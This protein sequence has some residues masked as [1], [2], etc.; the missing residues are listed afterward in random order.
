MDDSMNMED[1]PMDEVIRFPNEGAV[2]RIVAPTEGQIFS[3]GDDI[4]VKIETENFELGLDGGNHWHVYVDGITFGMIMGGDYNHVLRN[5]E[6]GEH[7]ISVFLSPDS[8]QELED[9]AMVPI[10]VE[11]SE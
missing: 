1:T 6:P 9:G 4:L 3:E 10:V 5:I 8:H 2:V 7:V 11:A